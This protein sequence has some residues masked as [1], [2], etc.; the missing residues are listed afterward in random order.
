MELKALELAVTYTAL[1]NYISHLKTLQKNDA[2]IK[3]KGEIESAMSAL[4]KVKADSEK[5]PRTSK[6]IR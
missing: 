2:S 3:L 4:K 5:S 1:E 6:Y